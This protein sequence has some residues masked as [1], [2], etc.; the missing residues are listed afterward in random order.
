L[1]FHTR[2]EFKKCYFFLDTYFSEL[3]TFDNCSTRVAGWT[4]RKGR[5]DTM[6]VKKAAK[7]APAKKAA[8][9]VAKKK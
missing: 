5:I 4:Y 1:R 2:E 8:K 7:K 6:A 9:K 3:Y